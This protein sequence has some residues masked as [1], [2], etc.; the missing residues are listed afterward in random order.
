MNSEKVRVSFIRY[1]KWT[2]IILGAIVAVL[3]AFCAYIVLNYQSVFAKFTNYV[4]G[5][6]PGSAFGIGNES[7]MY[8]RVE[9]TLHY[10]SFLSP[11]LWVPI[12]SALAILVSLSYFRKGKLSGRNT[13]II[14]LFGTVA[15]LFIFATSWLPSIDTH[16]FPIYPANTI[17][18]FL[19]HDSSYG[20]YSVWRDGV[21]DPYIFPENYSNIYNTYA[22][23]GYESC[24]NRSMI[25]F[26]KRHVANDSL[27][28]RL[29]GLAHLKYVIACNRV[30]TTPNLRRLFSVDGATLYENVLCKPRAYFAYR[31]I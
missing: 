27:N 26:Y 10:Y 30:I 6:I 28:L 9:K 24:T 31:S 3:V 25:V 8:G 5:A 21:T 22:F 13:L 23:H 1:F 29:L 12:I 20:R 15:E 18:S 16:K 19:E 4:S 14:V 11:V 2:K 17:M 7:W